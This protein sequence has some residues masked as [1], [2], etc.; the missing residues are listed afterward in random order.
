MRR[1]R[2][3]RVLLL[4]SAACTTAASPAFG[5][6][7]LVVLQGSAAPGESTLNLRHEQPA[8]CSVQGVGDCASCSVSCAT[9]QAAVCKPGKVSAAMGD[10]SCQREPVC[11]C[12]S[13]TP[14][15]AT[16]R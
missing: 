15:P 10:G 5:A 2:F 8:A 7:P 1:S 14:G 6:E 12:E 9:G 4:L 11:R 16:R 13:A 3:L